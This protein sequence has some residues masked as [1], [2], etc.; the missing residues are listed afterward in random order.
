MIGCIHGGK[1]KAGGGGGSSQNTGQGLIDGTQK[2]KLVSV[3][4][5]VCTFSLFV[6]L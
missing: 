1:E 6:P 4:K 5:K 3:E 2:G